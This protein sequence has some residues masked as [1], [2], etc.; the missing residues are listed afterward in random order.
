MSNKVAV[1]GLGNYA[2]KDEGAGIHALRYLKEN[3]PL[4]QA[5]LIEAGTSGFGMYALIRSYAR[6]LILDAV[7]MGKPAGTIGR[8][9]ADQLIA[10]QK[11]FSLHEMGLAEV[12]KLGQALGEDFSRVTVFGIQPQ[13]ISYSE[14]LS[15]VVQDKIPELA[16]EVVKATGKGGR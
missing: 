3:N 4:L 6:V 14:E 1:V 5:D 10:S 7:E 11:S 8:F 16:A 2:L 12:I 15:G 9:S 13:E